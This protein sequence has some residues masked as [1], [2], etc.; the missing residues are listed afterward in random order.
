[1]IDLDELS[2]I[3]DLRCHRCGRVGADALEHPAELRAF[4]HPA[5]L[6]AVARRVETPALRTIRQAD[7]ERVGWPVHRKCRPGWRL[8]QRGLPTPPAGYFDRSVR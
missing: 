4:L 2:Q 3:F 8:P 5:E 6:T 1:M 7:V